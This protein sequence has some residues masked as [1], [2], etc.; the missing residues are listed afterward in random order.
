[1]KSKIL[2]LTG[3]LIILAAHSFTG[4]SFAAE[5]TIIQDITLQA[6]DFTGGTGSGFAI[7]A[8]GLTVADDAVTA[9]YTSPVMQTPVA[10]NAAVPRWLTDIPDMASLELQ[11]R[12]R[13]ANGEW[14]QWYG[15]EENDDLTLP[16]DSDV[17][18]G[19]I[20]VPAADV[21]HQYFQLMVNFGRYQGTAA[22]VL[23][24]FTLTVIDSTAGPTTEE[25]LAQQAAL[26]ASRPDTNQAAEGNYPRPT[27]IS[28]EVWCTAADCDYTAGLAYTPATH[29]IIHHTVSSNSSSDWAAIVR[30]IWSFHTY[31]RGWGDI[32]YNYL[33]DRTGV[34]YEGHMNEDYQNL[35]VIGIHAADANAGSMG[36]ALIGTFTSA[37]ENYPNPTNPIVETPPPAM[38]DAAAELLAWK[39]SQ[40]NIDVYDASR[41]VN[42]S[43]GLPHL[44]GHRDVYGG[45]ATTCPGGSAY[46]LL[47]D[48]RDQVAQRLN[49][50]S[51]YFYID[52]L[53]SAFTKSNNSW[54]EGPRGCGNNGHSFYTFSVNDPALIENWGEWRPNIP[55]DG[56]YEIQ[57]YAPYCDTNSSET[58]GVIYEVTHAGGQTNVTINQNAEVG[59]WMSL[60]AFNLS[61]GNSTVIRLTD[62]APSDPV[63][64]ER[65]V[66]FDAIRLRPSTN[67][68]PVEVQNSQPAN[69]IW[70]RQ[71]AVTF[72]WTVNN[73]SLVSE[74]E[75]QVATEAAFSSLIY[76]TTVPGTQ[77]SVDHDF[78]Q[79]YARLYWRVVVTNV[80]MVTTTSTPTQFGIDA[81]MPTSNVTG[82]F[83]LPQGYYVLAWQG[84]DATSGVAA[85]NVD[86]RA[87]G[88]ATWTNLVASTSSTSIVFNPPDPGQ[89]YEFRSQATDNAG[90][91]E[92]AHTNP[93]LNTTQANFLTH[94]IML[95]I[96]KR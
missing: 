85:Y 4:P 57:V 24:Q 10:F 26:D 32:G 37:E 82:V 1:M 56:V 19:M 61:A 36:V 91:V 38:Q 42:M 12:T 87:S 45:T 28:R 49:F 15:I 22:P 3:S 40:R 58:S 72:N 6:T 88:S 66:W 93:D 17:T 16:G 94:V 55:E 47:S 34:I 78:G 67:L 25:L 71:T 70:S 95:P 92:P 60:G 14:S 90:N 11:I 79:D 64:Y 89:T 21:T 18:G 77:T 96:V 84:N 48:L 62:Y 73:P 13:A 2:A 7:T 69:D 30:A 29:M 80:Q 31:S 39:A 8:A 83:Q 74:T 35:D 81:T 52:E 54:H 44:M 86:Y 59:L 68:P 51:P 23:R 46:A 43:W 50:V 53:S 76:Q 9:V 33:I 41:L 65:A 5:E 75:L 27:V 20:A 63:N